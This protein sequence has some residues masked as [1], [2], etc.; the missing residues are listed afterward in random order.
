MVHAD[1]RE[2]EAMPALPLAEVGHGAPT[3]TEGTI[4]KRDTLIIA[5]GLLLLLLLLTAC[6]AVRKPVAGI[7]HWPVPEARR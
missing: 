7:Q 5:G 3:P 6:G 1:T 4:M 2:A